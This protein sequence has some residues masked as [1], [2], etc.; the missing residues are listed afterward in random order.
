MS[1]N[2]G[3]T[4]HGAARRQHEP[5]H[6]HLHDEHDH[7]HPTG[8]RGAIGELFRPHSHDAADSMDTALEAS[9]RGLWAVKISFAALMM[10]ALIQVLVI[11][12]T[13]SVAL[14]AD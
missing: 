2:H 1:N 3:E 12:A 14:L 4:G 9:E 5:S 7:A 6:D 10:T 13:G 11:W 8:W